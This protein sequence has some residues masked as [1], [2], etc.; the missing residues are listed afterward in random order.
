MQ[1]YIILLIIAVIIVAGIRESVK[2]FRGE[3]GCCGGSS[4]KPEKKKLKSR[5]VHT[6]VFCVED[7][8]CQNCV[9][10]VTGAINDI[11]GA[12]ARV[13]LKNKTAKV[14]CDRE[15]DAGTIREAI[16]KKGYVVSDVK[17]L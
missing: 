17:E 13:S 8:H 4:A 10:A 14:D 16:E 7:M 11:D 2:H 9:N 1:D 15:I 6:Y 12:A 5:V 3:G